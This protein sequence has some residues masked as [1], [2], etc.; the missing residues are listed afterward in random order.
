MLEFAGGRCLFGE[1]LVNLQ[2]MAVI[3][4]VSLQLTP[5]A[6][7]DDSTNLRPSI[8]NTVTTETTTSTTTSTSGGTT[9]TRASYRG[10]KDSIADY[11]PRVSPDRI[12]SDSGTA[13]RLA[14]YHWLDK[15]AA[16]DPQVIQAI[17]AH[18]SAARILAKHPRLGYIAESDHYLCR[19]L[20][21]WKDVARLMAKNGQADKVVEYDPEGIY[22][23]IRRDRG[24]ARRLAR[25]PNFD[26]MVVAN[27]DLAKFVAEYM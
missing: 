1:R 27:P 12:R 19:S 24:T 9:S 25:N 17:L 7:A 23:A 4:S 6:L 21:R 20:T 3:V 15:V 10:S 14:K 16:A 8:Q 18:H 11:P 5:Y 2:R 13:R 22:R 26:Q